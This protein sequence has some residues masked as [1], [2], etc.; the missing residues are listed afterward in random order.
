[1]TPKLGLFQTG[2]IHAST[3]NID[4]MEAYAQKWARFVERLGDALDLSESLYL[5][6]AAVVMRQAP[7]EFSLILEQR[8]ANLVAH[9]LM[10]LVVA[11]PRRPGIS[12]QELQIFLRAVQA[13]LNFGASVMPPG[14]PIHKMLSSLAR[15]ETQDMENFADNHYHSGVSQH[16]CPLFAMGYTMLFKDTQPLGPPLAGDYLKR[17]ETWTR[18]NLQTCYQYLAHGRSVKASTISEGARYM[19]QRIAVGHV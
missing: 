6:E 5:G 14:H 16:F 3:T 17:P 4:E 19:S 7:E 2:L 10:F 12:D 11:T 8:P 1:M 9:I 18:T 15:W 13:L